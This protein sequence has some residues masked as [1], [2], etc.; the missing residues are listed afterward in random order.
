MA[1]YSKEFKMK[2]IKNYL[3]GEGGMKYL[4]EKYGIKGISQ[5]QIW[6]NTYK[7]FGEEGLLRSQKNENYSVQF[8]LYAI[9][10]YLRTEMS[11][12][13]VANQL[14]MTNFSTA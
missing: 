2:I 11:Y 12:R 5:V 4:A 1:K 8:K 7:E 10:L 3:N 9:E 13:E 14:G 6:I